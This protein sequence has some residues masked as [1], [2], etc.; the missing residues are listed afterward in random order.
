MDPYW[1]FP[2]GTS[3]PCQYSSCSIL[4][5]IPLWYRPKPYQQGDQRIYLYPPHPEKNAVSH[6]LHQG[7]NPIRLCHH[8]LHHH[9]CMDGAYYGGLYLHCAYPW[10]TASVTPSTQHLFP[11]RN[12]QLCTGNTALFCLGCSLCCVDE[13]VDFQADLLA[14]GIAHLVIHF[15]FLVL[16]VSQLS[17]ICLSNPPHCAKAHP[18][19][20][21]PPCK[22]LHP[23]ATIHWPSR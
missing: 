13:T 15:L 18:Q 20:Q 22:L 4:P 10:V 2:T 1:R 3:S 6:H 14:F 11:L 12:H 8:N 17:G 9:L 5:P 16:D 21:S 23:R 7:S 19:C